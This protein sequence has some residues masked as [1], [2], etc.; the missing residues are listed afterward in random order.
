MTLQAT[1]TTFSPRPEAPC[2]GCKTCVQNQGVVM[3]GGREKVR[4]RGRGVREPRWTGCSGWTDG[5]D[6]AEYW[7][8]VVR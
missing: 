1:L 8:E 3:I 2:Y 6:R 5:T 7:P 4:C